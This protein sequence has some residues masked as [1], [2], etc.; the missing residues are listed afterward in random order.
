MSAFGFCR[1]LWQLCL[2]RFLAGLS[3]GILTAVKTMASE[4]A[5]NAEDRNRGQAWTES[6]WSIGLIIGP[7]IGGLLS[8]PCG[9]ETGISLFSWN[10]ASMLDGLFCRHPFLLP[11][12][13][14]AFL[15]LLV[16]PCCFVLPE[17]GGRKKGYL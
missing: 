9:K 7:A 5:Q 4:I 12:V 1:T 6:A 17:T 2:W 14:G 13:W 8:M 15:H 11:C 16:L 10:W 3:N